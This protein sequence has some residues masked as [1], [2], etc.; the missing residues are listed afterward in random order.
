MIKKSDPNTRLLADVFHDDWAEGPAADFAR[1]ASRLARR[2]RKLHATG[3]SAGAALVVAMAIFLSFN[4]RS[5]PSVNSAPI[6]PA[7]ERGYEIISDDELL[8]QLHDRS[9]MVIGKGNDG[10]RFVFLDQ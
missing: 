10:K 1:Q 3:L 5:A 6:A 8:A 7:A 9:L 4:Q 2:R